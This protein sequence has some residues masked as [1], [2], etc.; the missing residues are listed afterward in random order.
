M[1]APMHSP[2]LVDSSTL[3]NS[4]MLAFCRPQPKIPAVN[5]EKRLQLLCRYVCVV[6]QLL[7]DSLVHVHCV[8]GCACLLA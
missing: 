6:L 3:V 2:A 1:R 8:E 7:G 5:I 4:L